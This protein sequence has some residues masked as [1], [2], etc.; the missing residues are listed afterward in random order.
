M[1]MELLYLELSHHQCERESKMSDRTS[2]RYNQILKWAKWKDPNYDPDYST[3]FHPEGLEGPEE[4]EI[5]DKGC[6]VATHNSITV[7]GKGLAKLIHLY[8]VV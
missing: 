5:L 1:K 7:R 8:A 2:E 4:L 6:W 3:D